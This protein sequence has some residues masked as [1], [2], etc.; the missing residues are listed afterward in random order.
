MN[1]Y[2]AGRFGIQAFVFHQYYTGN[3]NKTQAI[4][5]SAGIWVDRPFQYLMGTGLV[6][7]APILTP[8]AWGWGTGAA[9][10]YATGGEESLESYVDITTD[11]SKW[12]AREFGPPLLEFYTEEY[13]PRVTMSPPSLE[14]MLVEGYM[15]YSSAPRLAQKVFK[16]RG[17]NLLF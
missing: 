16:Y 12:H 9:I 1:P 4:T 7:T 13:L 14:A 11:P 8:L 5:A 6:V 3:L 10:A 2:L 17:G 15:A